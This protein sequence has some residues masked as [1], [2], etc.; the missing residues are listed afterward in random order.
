MWKLEEKRREAKGENR[1][2]IKRLR[3]IFLKRSGSICER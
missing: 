2:E 3:K 1:S